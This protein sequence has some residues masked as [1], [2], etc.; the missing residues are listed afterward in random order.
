MARLQ[1]KITSVLLGREVISRFHP[2]SPTVPARSSRLYGAYPIRSA[3]V[4][5]GAASPGSHHPR[6]AAALPA[7]GIR[8]VASTEHTA[9]QLRSYPGTLAGTPLRSAVRQTNMSGT[10]VTAK[11]SPERPIAAAGPKPSAKA[12]SA[13]IATASPSSKSRAPS[14]R[15]VARCALGIRSLSRAEE[16]R[17]KGGDERDGEHEGERRDRRN[18]RQDDGRGDEHGERHGDHVRK[19]E[20]T[21]RSVREPRSYDRAR[22]HPDHDDTKRRQ[23][24][25]DAERIRLQQHVVD[26]ER[27]DENRRVQKDECA[28]NG[29]PCGDAHRALEIPPVA[30]VL[31][32][33]LSGAGRLVDREHQAC[34]SEAEETADRETETYVDR[35]EGRTDQRRDTLGGLIDRRVAARLF[36]RLDRAP[37]GFEAVIKEG[38][39]RAAHERGG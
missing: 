36:R 5:R 17:E 9:V 21:G 24:Q 10:V 29:P 22:L 14:D 11:I 32:P 20:A 7:L 30:Q 13:G 18:C 33:I 26:D 1:Q 35:G 2:A 23:R 38:R 6:F 31:R 27:Y 12:S 28:H 8:V 15:I 19:I 4:G 34:R 16:R 3:V 39:I 25:P 37:V